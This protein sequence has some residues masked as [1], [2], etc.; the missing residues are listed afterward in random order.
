MATRI[1]NPNTKK[2]KP[3][4][5]GKPRPR[6]T[7]DVAQKTGDLSC[8]LAPGS[9]LKIIG[10]GGIGCIV[11]EFLGRYL[12]S[13]RHIP[14][15]RLALI[16]GDNFEPANDQRMCFQT[17]GNKAEVKAA[18]A[19]ETLAPCDLSI[20]AVN[21]FVR[22]ENIADLIKSGDHVFLCVD[23][24]P[25]RRL[26]SEH[27]QTLKEVALFSGGNEG[28]D[29]PRERGVYG[30][31]QI[32]IRKNGRDVTAPLTKFHPEIAHAEGELPGGP[33]CGELAL[34]TPQ[35]LFANLA[36]ASAMCSA[37]FAYATGNLHYQEVKL[38]ILENRLLPQLSLPNS[39][40]A[41]QMNAR[42]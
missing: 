14:G 16:D 38:D 36:V 12:K 5:N 41:P 40:V 22:T 33:N 20:V 28:V 29:P 11:L 7:T 34:S 1:K 27:C 24:H 15:M 2:S 39:V 4:S 23:N 25:T 10:L 30:N 19:L 8:L 9:R 21:Q 13:Q 17:L 18:E 35:I 37:F 3:H 31:V 42:K 26:V 32:F 6:R